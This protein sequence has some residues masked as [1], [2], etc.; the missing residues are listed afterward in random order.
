MRITTDLGT[1]HRIIEMVLPVIAYLGEAVRSS[2]EMEAELASEAV[3]FVRVFSDKY[4]HGKEELHLFRVMETRGVPRDTGLVY[5]LLVEH[6]QGRAHVRAMAAALTAHANGDP[7]APYAF[8][9]HATAYVSL[10]RAH[11][12]TEDTALWD[13]CRRVLSAEDDAAIMAGAKDAEAAL[14]GA[15]RSAFRLRAQAL[16]RRCSLP[17]G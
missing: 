8:A 1:D 12:A 13:L 17:P 11:I 9:D 15:D 14:E 16:V 10:L 7:Q 2:G 5:Q 6:G 4:H 3:A